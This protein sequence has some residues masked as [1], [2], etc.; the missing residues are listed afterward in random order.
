MKVKEKKRKEKK[1]LYICIFEIGTNFPKN[2]S[3]SQLYEGTCARLNIYPCSTIIRSLNTT[4]IN[5]ENY[6]LG[7]RGCAALAAGLFVCVPF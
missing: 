4:K 2:K 3:C 7:P 6:G 5:L 1:K